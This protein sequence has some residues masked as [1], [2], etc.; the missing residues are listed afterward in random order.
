[1]AKTLTIDRL[2]RLV[3]PKTLRDRYGLEAGSEIELT[4]TGAGILLSVRHESS[5]LSRMANGFPVLSLP[6]QCDVDLPT[7]IQETRDDRD[8]R[9]GMF[10]GEADD[11]S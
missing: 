4:D 1:M 10:G 6:G 2:G 3:L 7:L 5:A 11:D 8:E 9:A